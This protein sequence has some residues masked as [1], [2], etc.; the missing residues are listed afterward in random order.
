MSSKGWVKLH[1]SITEHWLW[2]CEFSYAQAWVDLIIYANHSDKKLTIKGQLISLKRGQQARSEV[3]LSK[4]WKWSRNKV[5]RFL[6]NL[7]NDGMIVQETT[8]LTSLITICNYEDFQ[9]SETSDGTPKGH[10]TEHLKD[11]RRNTNKNVKKEKN[12]NNKIKEPINNFNFE[13]IKASWNEALLESNCVAKKTIVFPEKAKKDLPKIYNKYVSIKKS[14]GKQPD[15]KND[16]CKTY[17]RT[18]LDWAEPWA[19]KGNMENFK[20]S[21]E[22]S[23]R[24]DTFD[25]VMNWVAG[26]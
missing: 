11:I 21:L 5:R 19:G 18:V 20:V 16:F 24:I 15:S 4:T 25:K 6:K 7:E 13:E 12:D 2:D 3:T 1:R 26:E 8:H 23:V 17:F 10:L 9:H 14:L 22:Y